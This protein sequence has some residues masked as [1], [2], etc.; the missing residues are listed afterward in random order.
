M[1]FA[2]F[3]ASIFSKIRSSESSGEGPLQ[4]SPVELQALSK[5]PRTEEAWAVAQGR[6]GALW[7]LAPDP[8]GGYP[9]LT[10]FSTRVSLAPSAAVGEFFEQPADRGSGDGAE[11]GG[12]PGAEAAMPAA[13]LLPM[14]T[15]TLRT[16]LTEGCAL[17]WALQQAELQVRRSALLPPTACRARRRAPLL[18]DDVSGSNP[19]SVDCRLLRRCCPTRC[20]LACSRRNQGREAAQQEEAA[21]DDEDDPERQ[22]PAARRGGASMTAPT[23]RC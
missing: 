3:V 8:R 10:E 22:P 9:Q 14:Q 2:Y 7:R 23:P 4:M 1:Q 12:T 21:A 11:A 17:G 13:E 20:F 5:R 6:A 19:L 16:L 18:L 15:G